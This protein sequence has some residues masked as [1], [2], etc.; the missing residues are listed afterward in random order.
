M[1]STTHAAP[2]S[3]RPRLTAPPHRFLDRELSWLDFNERVLALAEDSSTPLLERA[4]FLAIFATNLDEFHLVR[5]AGLLRRR[6]GGQAR[7]AAPDL[8]PSG[9]ELALIRER[10]AGLALRHARLF[11]E[12]VRPALAAAG[13][14]IALRDELTPEHRDSLATT[15]AERIY[16]VLTPLA[17]HAGEAHHVASLSLN[18]AVVVEHPATRRT[19]LARVGVPP[20]LGRFLELDGGMRVPIEEVIA[21]NAGCLFPGMRIVEVAAFRVTHDADLE[22]EDDGAT[23]LLGRLEL[24]ASADQPTRAVRFEVESS[25]S[26][27]LLGHLRHDL[28]LLETDVHVLPGPLDLGALW[29]LHAVER[30]DLKDPPFEP[31]THPDLLSGGELLPDLFAAI[32]RQDVVLHHPY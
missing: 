14:R 31:R 22:I 2:A 21:A 30:P 6:A 27:V 7:G 3:V 24:Q 4:K 5:V 20:A 18:L 32:S 16:P 11:A 29:E 28:G 26:S 10:L 25:I 8:C 12:Q 13:L 17:A 15:F 23:D 9:A 19:R 1:A